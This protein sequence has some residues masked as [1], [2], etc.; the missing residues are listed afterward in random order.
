[1]C[2]NINFEFYIANHKKWVIT[3]M[4]C[5]KLFEFSG[6]YDQIKQCMKFIKYYEDV[7]EYA[8]GIF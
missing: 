6:Y 5:M 2:T 3:K 8:G 4:I 1:M 7:R